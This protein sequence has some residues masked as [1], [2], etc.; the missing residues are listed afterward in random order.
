MGDLDGAY[1]RSSL[2]AGDRPEEPEERVLARSERRRELAQR[3]RANAR[4]E[5]AIAERA[6]GVE[7]DS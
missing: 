6:G 5:R 3:L 7:E 1:G 4:R 2:R